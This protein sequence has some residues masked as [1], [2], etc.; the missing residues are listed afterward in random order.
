M[1]SSFFSRRTLYFIIPLT[2]IFSTVYIPFAE[3]TDQYAEKTGKG[4]IFCHRESTGGQLK[5]TGFAYIKN[6][7][8][9]PIP[10]R[11]L[12]KAESL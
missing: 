5:T 10:E 3:A 1:A 11:I 9:Y 12:I 6:G 7:Y 8:Q 4:C 2:I